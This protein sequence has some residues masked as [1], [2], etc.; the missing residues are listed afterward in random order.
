MT[1][2]PPPLIVHVVFRFAVGGLENGVVNLVNRLPHHAWRHAILAL[3]DIDQGFAK[4]I[5]R[6]DVELIGLGKGPGHALPLYPRIHSLLRKMRPAIVHTR[7]LAALEVVVPAWSARVPARIHGEHGRDATDPNLTRAR[8]RLLRRAYRPFVTHY[9]ALAPDLAQHLHDRIG[10]PQSRIDQIYNGVDTARFTP[11]PLR[12][13]PP[14]CPFTPGEHWIVGTVGRMDKVKDQV[15]LAQAFVQAVHLHPQA[16]GRMRLVMVGDGALRKQVEAVLAAAG[17]RELAWLA[18]ERDDIAAL[19]Q[20]FDCFVLP[21]LAEGV[22]NT[23][24]EAMATQLPV[25]ATRVGANAQL[26]E[27]GMSG[28]IV[29]PADSAALAAAMVA[30]F[31]DPA[32]ARRHGRA[33]RQ[34][35]E[36]RFSLGRMIDRYHALYSGALTGDARIRK[37]SSCAAS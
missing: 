9:V 32:L 24:L 36:K 22:S 18:G 35:A 19:L 16:R 20:S 8:Y 10:V 14:E 31:A 2:E 29:P 37:E 28:I 34:L 5:V 25:I 13:A 3:T 11:A 30:Y 23:I 7:N 6:S 1:S 15:N 33:G 26:V 4:R 27:D 12:A 17:M 21:S